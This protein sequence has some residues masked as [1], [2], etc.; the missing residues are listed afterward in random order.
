VVTYSKQDRLTINGGKSGKGAEQPLPV[1]FDITGVIN[2]LGNE[3]TAWARD[4]V[5]RHGWDVPDPGPRSPHNTTRG[6]VFPQSSPKIDLACYAALWLAEHAEPLRMHPAV[7]EAHRGITSAI[8]AAELAID[9]PVA[10]VFIG[11]CDEC[12][13]DL[14]AKLAERSTRCLCGALYTDVA[15]RWDR[16]L[17]KLR[18]YPA[19]AEVLAGSIGQ[20]YGVIISKRLIHSWHCRLTI[21]QVDTDPRSGEPRFRIGEVLDRAA[22]SKPR[23]AG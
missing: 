6:V 16:A 5:D 1:R 22:K 12:G 9:R 14:Y 8:A 13:G 18:G 20:L 19:T 15:Q 2:A 7:I 3:L 11:P 17:F 23:K 10:C 21:T 4:L